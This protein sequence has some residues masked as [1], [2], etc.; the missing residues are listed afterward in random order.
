MALATA[1]GYGGA[2]SVSPAPGLAVGTHCTVGLG[3]L[4]PHHDAT[5]LVIGAGAGT[6]YEFIDIAD[7]CV[8]KWRK[9]PRQVRDL[10]GTRLSVYVAIPEISIDYCSP[11]GTT[12]HHGAPALGYGLFSLLGNGTWIGS[13]V[14]RR[15]NR[16]VRV[17]AESI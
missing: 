14:E 3:D 10:H 13:G 1:L 15:V 2:V 12:W 7:G 5:G 16:A 11:G 4:A 6:N 8:K 17:G 9:C